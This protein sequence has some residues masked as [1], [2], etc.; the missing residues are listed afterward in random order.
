VGFAAANGAP[1]LAVKS[2]PARHAAAGRGE[3]AALATAGRSAAASGLD[4]PDVI[5]VT[6]RS[7]GT[8]E[9]TLE[10]LAGTPASARVDQ[11]HAHYRIVLDALTPRLADWHRR[12]AHTVTL[13]S[14][15][16]EQEFL[17][18]ARQ[19][20]ESA[21]AT[22]LERQILPLLGRD[23]IGVHAHRDLTMSNLLVDVGGSLALI[24]WE[25]GTVEGLPGTDLAYAAVDATLRAGAP[26][27]VAAF[28]AVEGQGT[29]AADALAKGFQSLQA[30][31]GADPFWFR[32]SLLGG[33]LHHAVNELKEGSAGAFTEIARRSASA[34]VASE[35]VD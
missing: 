21:V 34:F 32:L 35:A 19:V 18:P 25:H 28:E 15:R 12:T 13:D 30:A 23:V 24:D 14:P 8:V 6:E 31:S 16:L 33:W 4:T 17:R 27:R 22:C 10:I 2:F 20:L 11:V 9:L 29:A 5:E 3:V 1:L 7:D 26:D